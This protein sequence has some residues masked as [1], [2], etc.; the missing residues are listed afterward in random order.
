MKLRFSKFYMCI[1]TGLV[2]IKPS[3]GKTKTFEKGDKEVNSYRF[4][5][6]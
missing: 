1:F 4:K 2:R 5:K 3:I 6:G